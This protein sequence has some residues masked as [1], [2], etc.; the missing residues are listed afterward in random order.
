MTEKYRSALGLMPT[1]TKYKHLIA[2]NSNFM[3]I[4][5]FASLI[6]SNQTWPEKSRIYKAEN[7][8]FIAKRI[9]LYLGYFD[10][11]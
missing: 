1:T 5:T 2:Q 4:F 10:M 6:H 3:N 8:P 7:Q 11:I 9:C